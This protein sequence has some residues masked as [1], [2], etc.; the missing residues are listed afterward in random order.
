MTNDSIAP[1]SAVSSDS[2][3]AGASPERHSAAPGHFSPCPKPEKVIKVRK[4]FRDTFMDRLR[5]MTPEERQAT[6]G[7][8][9][10]KPI[11]R[12]TYLPRATKPIPQRNERRIARKNVS[13]RKVISSDFHKKLRYDRFLMANGLCECDRC[14]KIRKIAVSYEAAMDAVIAGYTRDEIEAAFTPTPVWFTKKGGEPWRRFRS[15][16]G[17]VHH[18]S[19]RYF[20][21]ENP[22][23]L[24]LI[25]WTWDA[26]H[27]EIE[28]E[29]GT[30][31]RFLSGRRAA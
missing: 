5:A 4:S 3:L 22:L 10:R 13:Y 27:K 23:E 11:A 24:Q 31:R 21:K 7:T 16:A 30:R 12:K 17:E 8:K 15:D 25:R 2:R 9:N 26:H 19:Y 18:D 28:A 14:A 1:V 20:G 29:F 6:Y